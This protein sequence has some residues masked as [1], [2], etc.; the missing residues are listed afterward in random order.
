MGFRSAESSLCV[1]TLLD[2]AS[3][4]EVYEVKLYQDGRGQMKTVKDGSVIMID[5]NSDDLV[6][7]YEEA[8]NQLRCLYL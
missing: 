8:G 4:C 7:T 5:G 2:V 3:A 1:P 6:L